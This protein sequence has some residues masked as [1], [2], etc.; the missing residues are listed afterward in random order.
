MY[1]FLPSWY[2]N[3]R[4]WHADVI[5]WYHMSFKIEFDDT[6]NQARVFQETGTPAKL[7]IL[8]YFPQVRYFLHRQD[9]LE[10]SYISVF[11][12]IQGIDESIPNRMLS[13]EDF[14]WDD[15]VEFA[16]SPFLVMVYKENEHIANVDFG[17][18]GNI[19]SIT[20]FNNHQVSSFMIVDDRGFISSITYHQEG[21]PV[22]QDYLNQDGDWVIRESIS[23]GTV[24]VNVSYL[25][26]FS[27]DF[28]SS[29]DKLIFEKYDE[30]KNRFTDKDTLVIASS[31]VHNN[32]ILLNNTSHVRTVF[33]FFS[34]RLN[35]EDTLDVRIWAY[36]ANL[37]ITDTHKNKD[38]LLKLDPFFIEKTHRISSF[39]TRLRLGNSQQ[40]KESKIYVFVKDSE[41]FN[42]DTIR[43]LLEILENDFERYMVFALYNAD[44]GFV[45]QIESSISEVVGDYFDS[46]SLEVLKDE[47]DKDEAEV[48]ENKLNEPEEAEELPPEYRFTVKNFNSETEIIKELEF[49]RL[50]VDL[51]QEPDLYTQIAGISA[52]IPQINRI[53]TEYVEHLKNG[54]II[55]DLNELPTA[56][57]YYLETLRPWNESLIYSVQKI[58]EN[59]GEQMIQ[60][61]ERWLGK[62]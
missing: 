40:K 17:P 19:I 12:M 44:G 9:L 3:E 61:W 14:E 30:I 13:I 22:Y 55:D 59:T 36:G 43:S 6:I 7:I 21:K 8:Q 60:K 27:K 51:S 41:E 5:P 58:K 33:S 18:E 39:D 16:Y 20:Y 62:S 47:E 26:Q 15:D 54:Y 1:Y 48:G 4:T 45:N 56:M 42:R 46:E 25:H 37:I 2:G 35:I 32:H 23:D 31:E 53:E 24:V 57:N 10:T 49:T 11:D 38:A 50:I 34:N 29:I 28:Y 52:G